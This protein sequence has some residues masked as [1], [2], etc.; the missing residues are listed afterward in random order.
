MESWEIK[1][2]TLAFSS[3]HVACSGIYPNQEQFV[4]AVHWVRSE[5]S[6]AVNT[7]RVFGVHASC[8]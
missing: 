8:S 2:H 5:L 7:H 1:L 4:D 6:L 3:V